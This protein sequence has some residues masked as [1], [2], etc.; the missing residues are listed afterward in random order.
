MKTFKL[1]LSTLLVLTQC[2]A[3]ALAPKS[4]RDLC[5]MLVTKVSS[6]ETLHDAYRAYCD[7]RQAAYL[8]YKQKRL[9]FELLTVAVARE[10]DKA[11]R[12]LGRSVHAY[13]SRLEIYRVI[14][15][16]VMLEAD[17][18]NSQY[19][20]YEIIKAVPGQSIVF[21]EKSLSGKKKDAKFWVYKNG[22]F[23]CLQF[24][25]NFGEAALGVPVGYDD[26]KYM[27]S[28]HIGVDLDDFDRMWRETLDEG[29]PVRMPAGA[30]TYMG[31]EIENA[32]EIGQALYNALS[33]NAG[34]NEG[35]VENFSTP[36]FCKHITAGESVFVSPKGLNLSTTIVVND[37][38]YSI[39]ND[40]NDTYFIVSWN[41]DDVRYEKKV[42]S[43]P[44]TRKGKLCILVSGSLAGALER[45]REVGAVAQLVAHEDFEVSSDNERIEILNKAFLA[46]N[47]KYLFEKRRNCRTN[48]GDPKDHFVEL[49]SSKGLDIVFNGDTIVTIRAR[50]GFPAGHT[51]GE[52][53]EVV[54]EFLYCDIGY[55]DILDVR[56]SLLDA[57]MLQMHLMCFAAEDAIPCNFVHNIR[58]PTE[59][60]R[61]PSV[62]LKGDVT[63][64]EVSH[65]GILERDILRMNSRLRVH[66]LGA[67]L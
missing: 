65:L 52:V 44:I 45:S 32:A 37:K 67:A 6:Y 28:S 46:I 30:K 5:E 21:R 64:E 31:N 40:S 55:R 43:F 12:E 60:R 9:F 24:A 20:N 47:A 57:V 7:S 14:F 2:S 38:E 53:L 33:E 18:Y 1:L 34:F 17:P 26:V 35:K 59:D 3:Y 16:E 50:D 63:A 62:A 19:R 15:F 27:G 42:F 29:G 51:G 10:I 54:H 25:R 58:V 13:P 23:E 56:M 49:C 48:M 61:M 11:I 4:A 41:E 22:S 8:N 39:A 66:L 36:K